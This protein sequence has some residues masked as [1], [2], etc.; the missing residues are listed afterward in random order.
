MSFKDQLVE[1]Q[2]KNQVASLAA[3]IQ[4]AANGGFRSYSVNLTPQDVKRIDAGL[5][6]SQYE[7]IGYGKVMWDVLVSLG[8][9]PKLLIYSDLLDNMVPRI[10]VEW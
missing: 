1:T 4:F 7:A 9:E 8:F 6:T 10:T 2:I 5:F 3:N